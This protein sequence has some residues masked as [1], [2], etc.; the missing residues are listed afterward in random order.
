MLPELVKQSADAS[1][2]AK[3]VSEYLSRRVEKI[4]AG[5][6]LFYA[7]RSSVEFYRGQSVAN[8]MAFNISQDADFDA[9]RLS[10]YP[11]ARRVDPT[12]V[13]NNDV[14]FRP[15]TWTSSGLLDCIGIDSCAVDCSFQL[16]VADKTGQYA[17]QN[18]PFMSGSLYCSY[19]NIY[20]AAGQQARNPI[21]E[22]P[23][24]LTFHTPMQIAR[25]GSVICRVTPLFSGKDDTTGPATTYI[26]YKIVGVLEGKKKV[27]AFK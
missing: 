9:Y 14:T 25:G 13:A 1:A 24:C 27:R 19:V 10:I 3:E 8:N 20:S 22:S 4:D 5:D 17:Y 23:A 2:F 11:Y 16:S 12:S 18:I 21:T 7:Y 6:D 26:Q 15:T